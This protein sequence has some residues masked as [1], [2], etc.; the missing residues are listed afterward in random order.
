VAA[1]N[2]RA[3]VPDASFV[4]AVRVE[5]AAERRRAEQRHAELFDAAETQQRVARAYQRLAPAHGA[6]VIDGE[7]SVDR[8]QAELRAHLAPRLGI[9]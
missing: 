4:L 3:R 7:Q 8:V 6:V 2:G 5:V 1:L 9:E